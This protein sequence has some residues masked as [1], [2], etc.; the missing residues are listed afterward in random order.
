[1]HGGRDGKQSP[2]GSDELLADSSK[3]RLGAESQ[4]RG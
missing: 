2:D 1:M 3:G 4:Q